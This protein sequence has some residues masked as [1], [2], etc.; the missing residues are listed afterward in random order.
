MTIPGQVTT[1]HDKLLSNAGRMGD[2]LWNY[3][4]KDVKVY[5]IN[6]ECRNI[7]VSIS[8]QLI[9]WVDQRFA[10][11]TPVIKDLLTEYLTGNIILEY[12]RTKRATLDRYIGKTQSKLGE[13]PAT[14]ITMQRT[15]KRNRQL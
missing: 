2:L 13:D 10:D 11:K 1:A 7:I 15:A 14:E 12:D 8:E 4:W 5:S 9:T 3:N 6:E